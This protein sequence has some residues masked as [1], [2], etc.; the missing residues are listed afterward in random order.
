LDWN[1]SFGAFC[2]GLRPSQAVHPR[3]VGWFLQTH[4]YRNRVSELAAGVNI[5]N[6]R[7]KHIEE[8]RI[9]LPPLDE[10]EGIVAEI[11]KQFT[12]LDAGLTSLKRAQT[13]LKRYR[14]SVLKAACE[15]RLVPIEAELARKEN[16]S[17][18]TGEELLQLILKERRANGKGKYKNPVAPDLRQVPTLPIG[19][20]AAS[21]DQISSLVTDGDHNPPKRQPRGLPHL[22]AKN[23][24]DWRLDPTGCTYISAADA[25]RVLRRYSP[26][27]GDLIITCVGTVGRTAI[28]PHDFKFSP[29]RNLAAVRL[30]DGHI[31][32]R[33]LNIVL[34]SPR[35]QELIRNA[36]GATAQPH[37]YLGD[38]RAL[39]IPLPPIQEQERIVAEVERRLSVTD[40]AVELV[41]GNMKRMSKLREAFL[42]RAFAGAPTELR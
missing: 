2:F 5:N 33:Y 38:L 24:R 6:L 20:A 1:G 11:E 21:I 19:W 18:E 37:F 17:Y 28:V 35:Y 29:D 7:A 42:A 36:S 34:S 31:S 3:F 13:A 30:V 32:T 10:Q 23:V 4:E 39:T 25:E 22:T 16:R 8:I 26:A 41:E 40:E 9:R 15:G 27:P 12:R 14:G